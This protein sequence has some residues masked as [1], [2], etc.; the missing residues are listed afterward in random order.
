[1]LAKTLTW[2]LAALVPLDEADDEEHQDEQSDGAHQP[3]EPALRGDVH[4]ST[5]HGY[6]THKDSARLFKKIF[7]KKGYVGVVNGGSHEAMQICNDRQ[8]QRGRMRGGHGK[9]QMRFFSE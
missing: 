9:S 5:G 3:N 4:V 6:K 2:I 8:K 7:F 1:M